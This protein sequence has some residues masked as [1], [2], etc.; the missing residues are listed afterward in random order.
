GS[1]PHRVDRI[2]ITF[3]G[4]LDSNVADVA[5]G[6]AEVV[7]GE[8]PNEFR[9]DLE[10]RYGVNRSQLFQTRGTSITTIY[11][12]TSRPLFKNNPALR[13]AVNLAL[14]RSAIVRAGGSTSVWRTPTDQILTHWM[15]GWVDHRLYPLDGP[16]LGLAR[17]L[18]AENLRG[19]RAVLWV[20]PFR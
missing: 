10:R 3:G 4:D 13:K 6:R 19:G 16:N 15:P 18:A 20:S 2:V 5:E 8:L 9:L 1:R 7:G 17:R 11:M 14:D 12:N